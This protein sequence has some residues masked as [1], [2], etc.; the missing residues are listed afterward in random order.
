MTSILTVRFVCSPICH[1]VYLY[2]LRAALG[3][4]DEVDRLGLKGSKKKRSKKLDEDW[5][6]LIADNSCS[7]ASAEARI[8]LQP[9]LKPLALKEVPKV[10]QAMRQTQSRKVLV[11][12]LTRIKVGLSGDHLRLPLKFY[13]LDVRRSVCSPPNDAVTRVQ[14]H[15]EYHGRL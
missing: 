12:L 6:V 9:I 3:I 11:K 10:I 1:V 2:A 14:S 7:Y 15:D 5:M 13:H 4:A 8:F